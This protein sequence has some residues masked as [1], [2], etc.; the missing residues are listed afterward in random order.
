MDEA[1]TLFFQFQNKR[2]IV[3]DEF[4]QGKGKNDINVYLAR[5]YSIIAFV[6]V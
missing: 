3:R 6:K 5:M 2:D 1:E 4:N